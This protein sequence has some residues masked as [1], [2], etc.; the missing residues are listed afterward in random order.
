LAEE[1]KFVAA[2]IPE[3]CTLET[4]VTGVSAFAGF[5]MLDEVEAE[6]EAE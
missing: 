6:A 2:F 5:G 1:D 3:V 4:E